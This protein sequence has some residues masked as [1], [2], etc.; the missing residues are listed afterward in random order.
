ML[1]SHARLSAGSS[2]NAGF[3]FCELL[4]I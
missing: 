1:T 2:D 4:A 3:G